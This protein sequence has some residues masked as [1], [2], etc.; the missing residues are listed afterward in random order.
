MYFF[1]YVP[2]SPIQVGLSDRFKVMLTGD[3][4]EVLRRHLAHQNPGVVV[5]SM[6]AQ[7]ED[8]SGADVIFVPYYIKV[9]SILSLPLA[10]QRNTEAK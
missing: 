9:K 6:A 10:F 4:S 8:M 7:C 1:Y 2:D 3:V 5:H